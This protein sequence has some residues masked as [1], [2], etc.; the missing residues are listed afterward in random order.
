M[1]EL[2]LTPRL[3]FRK[4]TAL[5]PAKK[6]VGG[7]ADKIWPICHKSFSTFLDKYL[8]TTS[9]FFLPWNAYNIVS[10]LLA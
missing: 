6:I 1:C 9:L 2:K 8:Q 3:G 5:S 10:K 4:S 7:S